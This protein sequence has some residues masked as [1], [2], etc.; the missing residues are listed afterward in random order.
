MRAMRASIWQ[1][2]L[3]DDVFLVEIT[4]PPLDAIDQRI[5]VELQ[6]DG[7][8][9][10]VELAQRVGL[11]ATPCLRRLKRLEADG[12]IAR[13]AALIDTRALGIGVQ[14]LV[15]VTLEDHSEAVVEAFEAAIRER[16]EVVACF[17]VTGEMD[18]LMLVQAADLDSYSAFALRTLL[19]MPGVKGSRSSFIM[20]TVKSDLAYAPAPPPAPPAKRRR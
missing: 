15:E 1:D 4:V 20:Q 14:A 18:F 8:L 7:R 12:V 17:A 19:R 5:V 11:S 6:R 2:S 3:K 16:P 10:I 13:Y 9:P